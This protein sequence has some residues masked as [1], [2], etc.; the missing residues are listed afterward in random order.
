M[1]PWGKQLE[2]TLCGLILQDEMAGP[3]RQEA[4]PCPDRR[5]EVIYFSFS[6]SRG[7]PNY[8]CAE[9]LLGGQKRSDAK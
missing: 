6:K 5:L 9:R 3:W 2:L 1:G 7:L 4:G 8:T